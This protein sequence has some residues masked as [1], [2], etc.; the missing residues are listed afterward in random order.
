[1]AAEGVWSQF[2][3]DLT[4]FLTACERQYGIA[5]ERYT[6]YVID[7]LSLS[8]QSV[9]T[10]RERFSSARVPSL[11]DLGE[12]LTEMLG[13]LRRILQLWCDYSD[14]LSLNFNST[15][16]ELPFEENSISS[17][18]RP[19]FNIAREQLLYLRSLSFSWT[20]IADMLM[21]SRMTIYRRRAE[22]G[23]LDDP[24]TSIGEEE[25]VSIV[26]QISMEHPQ[27]GQSFIMGRL[28]SLGYRVTRERVR[29]AVRLCDPLSTALRWHGNPAYRRPYS[30]PGPN[31]LWH[32][33]NCGLYHIMC[34]NFD[35]Q[36]FYL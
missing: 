27:V 4:S 35:C 17:P 32:I 6:K 13:E 34:N 21:V 33:G 30:V 14:S 9:L 5:N 28:R 24:S 10:L 36:I 23:M 11:N 31:S 8:C 18:S 22:F 12:T 3:A 26:R 25:L 7:H 15:R 16:Y 29:Q 1:M 20:A 19:R 2:F